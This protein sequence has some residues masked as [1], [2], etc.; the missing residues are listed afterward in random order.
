MILRDER[1]EIWNGVALGDHWK[2]VFGKGSCSSIPRALV[3][4]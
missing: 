4:V 3:V 2:R 1:M